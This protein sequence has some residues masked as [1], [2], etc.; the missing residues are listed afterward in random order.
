MPLESIEPLFLLLYP[1]PMN[2]CLPRDT[3]A[4]QE[5][6]RECFGEESPLYEL[7][8]RSL[9]AGRMRIFYRRVMERATNPIT[10][11]MFR[12]GDV[13][14]RKELERA[15]QG[16][17]VEKKNIRV[18]RIIESAHPASYRDLDE[19]IDL[20]KKTLASLESLKASIIKEDFGMSV[21]EF[22]E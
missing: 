14:A 21:E 1:P 20:L 4:S 17:V 13:R 11:E 18:H 7:A 22:N 15:I 8:W 19:T 2:P 16:Y 6:A 3:A 9:P 10:A 12:S 5:A